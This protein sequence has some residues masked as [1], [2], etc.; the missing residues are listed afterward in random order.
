MRE[1]E[2]Y[3]EPEG[4]DYVAYLEQLERK[5]LAQIAGT[6]ITMAAEPKTTAQQTTAEPDALLARLQAAKISAGSVSM[7][8]GIAAVIGA[9]MVFL[10]IVGEGNFVTL[11]IG[12]ALLWGPLQRLRRT[13]RALDPRHNPSTADHTFGKKKS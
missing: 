6:Q 2:T 11:A 7:A 1:L 9:V 12:I 5:Q 10:S 13:V 8:E 3:R 4:G